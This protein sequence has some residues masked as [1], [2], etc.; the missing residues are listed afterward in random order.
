MSNTMEELYWV[1]KE[2]VDSDPAY[3]GKRQALSV[4]TLAVVEEL[5][6]LCGEKY[7]HLMD[8]MGGLD[9][10]ARELHEQ[11]LFREAVRLGM[12]LGRMTVN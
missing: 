7:V 10:S 1:I 8:V 2:Q 5:E 11:L 3:R 4:A 6:N 12:E 9:D